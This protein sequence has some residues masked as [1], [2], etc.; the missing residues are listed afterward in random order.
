MKIPLRF[1]VTEFDCGTVSLLN[2]FSYL[3]ERDEIPALLIK[4]I[5]KYTLDTND[6]EGHIGEGG[7]SKEAITKL[8]DWI[9]DYTKDSELNIVCKK[10]E[11][12]SVTLDAFRNC[13]NKRGC[14]LLRCFM[15]GEHYVLVTKLSKKYVYLFDPYYL[16][17][18][19][20]MNDKNIKIILNKPF[21]YNRKVN[22]KRLLEET[23]NDLAMGSI[24]NREC[25]LMY[26][27]SP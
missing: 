24:K 6:D 21:T 26:K 14:I 2:A 7:T 12:E 5:Y 4:T 20:Y 13:L 22:I 11:K 1:Q 23:E 8:I 17:K 16:D 10:L 15:G 9:M 18:D 19:A 27:K 3:Y 25:V